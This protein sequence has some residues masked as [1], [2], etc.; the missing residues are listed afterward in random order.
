MGCEQWR[1]A[2][3]AQLDGEESAAERD[4]I[5]AHLDGCADCRDW[6]DGAATVTRLARTSVVTE[7]PDLDLAAAVLAALPPRATQSAGTTPPAGAA[8]GRLVGLLRTG[9][10]VLGGVQLVLGLAQVGGGGAGT[11]THANAGLTATAGHL[12]HES[13]AWNVAIGAGFLFIAVRRTRPTGLLPTLSAFVAMLVLLSVSDLAAAMV[14]PARLISHGFVLA[15]YLIV[16][17]LSRPGLDPGQ[18]PTGQRPDRPA[19]RVRFADPPA[20]APPVRLV[21]RQPTTGL[22]GQSAGL[23]EPAGPTWLVEPG[24]QQRPGAGRSGAAMPAVAGRPPLPG[25]RTG[26]RRAA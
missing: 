26:Q 8:R 15:G 20:A 21:R 17:A 25:Q 14:E 24:G 16:V 1:E 4:G 9:L 2:L 10:G 5:D 7:R 23:V 18:P 22:T 19:W 11:H 6:L 13:A 12:W 3:S